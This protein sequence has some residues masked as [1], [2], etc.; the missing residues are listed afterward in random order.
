M[1]AHLD[2]GVAMS[3]AT[4]YAQV[5]ARMQPELKK[6]GE[7]ALANAGYTPTQA[8]RRLYAFASEHASAPDVVT[9]YVEGADATRRAKGTG[10]DQAARLEANR[11][12]E[13]IV[14]EYLQIYA[15]HAPEGGGLP[16]LDLPDDYREEE[17][18]ERYGGEWWL[19]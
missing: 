14:R 4:E 12:V 3:V 11:G 16:A 1:L 15:R 19:A 8:I 6:K 18:A 10:D 2:W 9:D 5:N 7:A 13:S 17:M